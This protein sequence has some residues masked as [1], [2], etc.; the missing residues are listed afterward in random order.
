MSLRIFEA[1]P[2]ATE[3]P[4]ATV[5]RFRSGYVASG[6]PV[7]L[8]TWRVTSGDA[9][10]LD[11]LSASLGLADDTSID[12]WET[13]SGDAFELF[14]TSNTVIIN[15]HGVQSRMALWGQ[16]GGK[17]IRVCD[18]V[19]QDNGQPCV[20]PQGSLKE[21]KE[22][23]RAG[24]GC[25]PDISL[26]FEVVGHEALGKFRFNSGSWDLAQAINKVEKE[27]EEADGPVRYTLALE[28]VT[29]KAKTGEQRSYT[30][31]TLTKEV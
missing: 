19:T 27:L 20:C 17:P 31:P 22:A 28:Q 6:R 13:K 30:K 11:T 9:D 18:G 1:D 8:S 5:G 3:S 16:G 23:A 21:R 24:W 10:V 2:S 4:N 12:T 26:L 14:T 7:A 29:Y 15:L 25:K